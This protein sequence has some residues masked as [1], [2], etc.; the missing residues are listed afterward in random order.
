MVDFREVEIDL[1]MEMVFLTIMY[2]T[3]E[4]LNGRMKIKARPSG[5]VV[6]LTEVELVPIEE[7][8]ILTVEVYFK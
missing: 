4:N 8:V 2:K 5:K 1:T 6:I 3:R 7:E